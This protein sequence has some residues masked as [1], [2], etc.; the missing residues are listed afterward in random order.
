[1][2]KPILEGQKV[3]VCRP[4]PSA[5][6][7][8]KVLGSVGAQTCSLPCIEVQ[9]IENKQ[10]V[11]NTILELDQYEK[12]VVV[13]QHAATQLI[14]LVDEYWPQPPAMQHWFGI[15]RKTTQLLV[16]AGLDVAKPDRDYSSEGLLEISQLTEVK[17][18]KILIAKGK[19]G[20]SKLEQGLRDRGAKVQTIELYQRVAPVYT[21]QELQHSLIDFAPN[22]IVTLSA[23]TLDNLHLFATSVGAEQKNTR[24]IVPSERVAKH[25]RSLGYKKVQISEQLRPIDIIKALARPA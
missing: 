6:E 5:T 11:K 1:M 9:A 12:V 15:G 20:R 3:L 25:A 17:G 10:T 19:E 18:Q 24:L 7:L 4:E 2:I 8:C 16:E 13:S 23:E 22:S 14:A 21:E